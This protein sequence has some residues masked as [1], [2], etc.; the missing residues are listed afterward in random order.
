MLN[1]GFA[2]LC[3]SAFVMSIGLGIIAPVLPIYAEDLGASGF[4]LGAIYSITFLSMALCNPIMGRLSDHIGKK[5]LI[6][7]GFGLAIIISISYAW[8][9]RPVDLIVIRFLQGIIAAMVLPIVMAFIGELSPE[10]Q[11]GSYMGVYSMMAFL[12]MAAGPLIGG[13]IADTWGMN[14]AFYAL[15]ISMGI[16]FVLT[17]FFLPIYNKEDT[18]TVIKYPFKKMFASGP[19]KGIFIF[20]FTLAIAQ[21]GL[22]VFLPLLAKNLDLSITQ[23]GLLASSFTLFAGLLQ[24]LFGWVANRYNRVTLVM[25]GTLLAGLGLAYIPYAIDF[26]SLFALSTALGIASAVAS[27]AANALIVEHGREI[28]LGTVSGAMN[29][30]TC[31]GMIVGPVAAGIV[32]DQININYAFYFYA[33]IF[34]IGACLFYYFTKDISKS[35]PSTPSP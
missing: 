15:A 30:F 8:A 31:L 7:S 2:V 18:R 34:V 24:P 13:K 25:L 6:S 17:L 16:A 10:G 35:I 28:G 3:I 12:G 20:A 9:N 21:S 32:M 1:R 33:I 22:M 14:Y 11:E 29:T 26:F 5:I 23:I 19:L 4:M 27:P